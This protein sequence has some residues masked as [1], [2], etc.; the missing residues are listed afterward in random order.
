M[1]DQV[2]TVFHIDF[3]TSVGPN[4]A[5]DYLPAQ[6][7]EPASAHPHQKFNPLTNRRTRRDQVGDLYFS[8]FH[9]AQIHIG[10]AEGKPGGFRRG[11]GRNFAKGHRAISDHKAQTCFVTWASEAGHITQRLWHPARGRNLA[12]VTTG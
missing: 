10:G 3:V 1:V 5:N 11:E 9:R 2:G 8:A 7:M 6:E 4:Y 12:R